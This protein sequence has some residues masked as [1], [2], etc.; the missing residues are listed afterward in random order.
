MN[1]LNI[2]LLP[3]YFFYQDSTI[4]VYF[5]STSNE[6]FEYTTYRKRTQ[7]KE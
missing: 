3:F 4:Y 5:D 6:K 1:L 2:L 7:S